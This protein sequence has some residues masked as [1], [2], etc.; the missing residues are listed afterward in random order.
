[1]GAGI[2][3]NYRK[4]CCFATDMNVGTKLI[5]NSHF[6]ILQGLAAKNL[7]TI[8]LQYFLKAALLE[9]CGPYCRAGHPTLTFA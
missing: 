2:F 4:L 6:E 9:Q 5:S 3:G 8:T 1:M 7:I